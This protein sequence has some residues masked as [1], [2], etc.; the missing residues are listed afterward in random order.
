MNEEGIS[1]SLWKSVNDYKPYSLA[2]LPVSIFGNFYD[3]RREQRLRYLNDV[4]EKVLKRAGSHLTN[5]LTLEDVIHEEVIPNITTLGKTLLGFFA[6]RRPLKPVRTLRRKPKPQNVHVESCHIRVRVVRAVNV[7]V[8]EEELRYNETLVQSFVEVRFGKE[9]SKTASAH[10]PYPHWNEEL[11]LPFCPPDDDF[12]PLALQ[13]IS[14][15]LEIHLYDEI[16]VNI[17]MDEVQRHQRLE[18]KWLGSLTIPFSTLHDRAR[19]D[20]NLK[21]KIVELDSDTIEIHISYKDIHKTEWQFLSLIRWGMQ[22]V[23]LVYD[24][25]SNKSFETVENIDR[26]PHLE[27][28]ESAIKILLVGNKIDL[29]SQRVVPKEK[30][31]WLAQKRNMLFLET[32]AITG[33]NIDEAFKTIIRN[34]KKHKDI[35]KV[36]K[37]MVQDVSLSYIVC[38]SLQIFLCEF[39]FYFL[40][41]QEGV[42]L[43]YIIH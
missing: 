11:T 14:H 17:S 43:Y 7:P 20:F 30:G 28:G 16:T 8:R 15:E 3:N 35:K 21:K 5:E 34:I 40:L 9:S 23:M 24:V 39:Y 13:K 1:D 18:K 2:E 6:P 29:G 10:G 42:S 37:H 32:S 41:V 26:L 33:S 4:R 19:V 12:S 25:T 27:F 36:K 31:E 22:G 38:F